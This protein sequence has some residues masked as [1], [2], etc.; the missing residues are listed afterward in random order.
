MTPPK[1]RSWFSRK[2]TGAG[3]GAFYFF[4]SYSFLRSH[5]VLALFIFFATVLMTSITSMMPNFRPALTT[6]EWIQRA[7]MAGM[8]LV[9]LAARRS[10]NAR[11][12]ALFG[13][14]L[15]AG[16]TF[17]QLIGE[18]FCLGSLRCAGRANTLQLIP[19]VVVF[20]ALPILACLRFLRAEQT[21]IAANPEPAPKP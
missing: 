7:A 1:P 18:T 3:L 13:T 17:I 8:A 16:S 20:V 15:L 21:N 2:Y 6:F 12:T 14:T 11:W 4:D 10:T 5:C 19:A 9:V